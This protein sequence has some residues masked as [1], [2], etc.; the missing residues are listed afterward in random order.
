MVYRQL[1]L[2]FMLL[3]E[4]GITVNELDACRRDCFNE[5]EASST[6]G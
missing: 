5:G 6:S 2:C 4:Y 3:G 1:I